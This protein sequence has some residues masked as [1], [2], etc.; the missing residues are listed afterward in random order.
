MTMRKI[1]DAEYQARMTAAQEKMAAEG[2]DAIIAHSHEA[3]FAN[4]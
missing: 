3:D 1:S 4:V 2:I